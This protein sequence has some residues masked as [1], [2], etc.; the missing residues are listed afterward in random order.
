MI[1]IKIITYPKV[2]EATY[3]DVNKDI[4][5]LEFIC[6]PEEGVNIRGKKNNGD[7]IYLSELDIKQSVQMAKMILSFFNDR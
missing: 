2:D 5:K 1:D 6:I 7:T 3:L 4:E